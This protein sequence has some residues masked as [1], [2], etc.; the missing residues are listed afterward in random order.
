MPFALR[1][2]GVSRPAH[3]VQIACGHFTHP[4]LCVCVCVS[5]DFRSPGGGGGGGSGGGDEEIE[6]IVFQGWLQKKA[7][8]TSGG[9]MSG[10][11]RQLPLHVLA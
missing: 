6:E 9:K 4:R 5:S 10:K 2:P 7:G 1:M 3:V 8:A 11:R